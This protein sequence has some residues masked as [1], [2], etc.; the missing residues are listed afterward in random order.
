[1]PNTEWP[2]DRGQPNSE[3]PFVDW[4][5]TEYLRLVDYGL[6]VQLEEITRRGPG[7]EQR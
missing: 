5:H 2:N 3:T 1:M 6:P 7:G 4:G